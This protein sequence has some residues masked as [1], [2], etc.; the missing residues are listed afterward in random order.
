MFRKTMVLLL[1]LLMLLQLPLAAQA[2]A[3]DPSARFSDVPSIERDGE[4][5]RLNRRLTTILLMGVDL[6]LEQ[7]REAK[8]RNGGQSDFLLL[9]VVNDS[10][11]TISAIQI[12]RDTIV[13]LTV[14]NSAGQ[15]VGTRRG[16]ICLSHG[17]GDG[18]ERSCELVVD[19]VSKLLNDT[20]INYYVRM[21][22]EGIP[23][24]ND[25]LGGVEVT[26]EPEEDFTKYDPAMTP[27]TTLTLRGMQAEYYTRMRLTV[28]DGTNASRSV[29]Q[30]KYM[31]AALP[32]LRQRVEEDSGF[33][34]SLFAQL[35]DYLATNISRGAFYNLADKA[36][37]YE[38]TTITGIEGE[39]RLG[40]DGFVEFYPDEA[41]LRDVLID[42]LYDRVD[43]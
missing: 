32:L 15:E 39:H 31:R 41:S 1:A 26:L 42:V 14:L 16:Q 30:R 3:G 34:R 27:G 33:V 11:K 36:G 13:D 40:E 25:A 28:G 12:D 37:R 10:D 4:L 8:F 22:M 24:L 9:V 5:Y 17:F 38:V 29:R 18:G 19:A 2:A 20:P 23:A 35:E 6:T 7:A 21:S 43:P